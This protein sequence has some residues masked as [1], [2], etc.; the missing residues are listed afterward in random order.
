MTSRI[1]EELRMS[2]NDHIRV[3][4]SSRWAVELEKM[5]NHVS[6]MNYLL[7]GTEDGD[8]SNRVYGIRRFGKHKAV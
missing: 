2:R 6:G 8:S 5:E 7:K 4:Q 1:P 3:R